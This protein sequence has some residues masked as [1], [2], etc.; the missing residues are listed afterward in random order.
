[1]STF[2]TEVPALRTAVD[3]Q[4][5]HVRSLK[6]AKT[7]KE[8]L[9]PE[10]LRLQQLKTALEAAI[11]A[12]AANAPKNVL[13]DQRRSLED[14]LKRR[15]V[16]GQAFEI[17]GGV[18]GLFD[19]GPPGAAMK[20][21]LISLWRQH[22]ILEEGLLEI[23]CT[24]L[25]P[26]PVLRASGHVERFTDFM[27]RDTVT[28]ECYRADKLLA[29]HVTARALPNETNPTRKARLEQLVHD[30]D[31]YS[32]TELG[33]A[34]KEA[35]VVSDAGNQVSEPFPF[36]LMFATQ[37]G[38]SG[39]IPGFLRPETAQGI[40]VNF[41][42]LLDYAGGKLP[43]GAA[44][45]GQAFRNEIAPR[46]GLLRVRE[47]TLAEIEFFVHPSR[48]GRHH[49]KFG[50]IRDLKV[51]LLTKKAQETE[52]DDT[53][54][55]AIGDAISQGIIDNET[56]GY[57]IGRTALFLKAAGLADSRTH[58]PTPQDSAFRFRQHRSTEMA[59]YA[60]DC[61][62][63]EIW[64]SYGWVEC[65][66]IADRSCFDLGRHSEKSG[67][68]LVAYERFDEPKDIE[69]TVFKFDRQGLGM[70]LKKLAKP[71][72]EF[73][74]ATSDDARKA[75]AAELES[76]GFITIRVKPEADKKKKK[77]DPES[78]EE[79]QEVDVQVPKQYVTIA[80]ETKRIHGQT[81]TPSVIEPSFGLGRILYSLLEHAYYVRGG[82]DEARAVLSLS[83]LIAPYKVALLPLSA[84]DA[85]SAIL[86]EIRRSLSAVGVSCKVDDSGSS[87]GRRYARSD[88]I[89]IPFAVTVDFQSIENRTATIRE[90][91]TCTQIRVPIAE[92][93]K[94]C[95]DLS[96]GNVM[97]ADARA[98]YPEQQ[99][100]AS[101]S[102]GRKE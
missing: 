54:I 40:F 71:A 101:D 7:A 86:G 12:E 59:H 78:A 39:L 58:G 20:D 65:V 102:V 52:G 81:F 28:H 99:Q 95:Y 77:D 25:T 22:F 92:I 13:A 100:S 1:M 33:A 73:L 5:R 76:K 91:D 35:G 63:A 8:A 57:F 64:T 37:I 24:C 88:E 90:R 67:S 34:L 45:I 75:Y 55:M 19:Y 66:G 10:I 87:V 83:P 47:F 11:A 98:T 26:D 41:R 84:N 46:S 51:P 61:W 18:A 31:T 29:E 48:E 16:V 38:P 94:L 17:Y 85:F 32:Q 82:E 50:S 21:A 80:T 62:D 79:P 2:P 74:E 49:S 96:N 93:A 97:W 9:Q 70:A 3:D 89:G 69:V 72:I 23:E 36:N 4:A 43:F 6:E 60:N 68:E 56:L 42:R 15:F 27:V 30:V 14:L 53:V 44:T